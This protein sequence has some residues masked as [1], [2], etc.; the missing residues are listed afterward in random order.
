MGQN[1]LNA[2]YGLTVFNRTGSAM[3]GIV[4]AGAAPARSPREVAERSDVLITVLTD[5]AAV[6]NIILGPGGVAEGAHRGLTV[7]D[8]STIS[9]SV[10]K[11]ISQSLRSKG[12]S[13]L[14]APV[15]GGDKGAREGTLTIMVGGRTDTFESCLPIL[16]VLGKKVAHMGPSGA[17]QFAKLANQILVACNTAGVCECLAFAEK[18]GLDTTKM[19]ES[20]SAGAASSWALANLGPKMTARDFAPGFKVKLLDKD[21]GYVLSAGERLNAFLPATA[22]VRELYGRLEEKGLGDQGTQALFTVLE[23]GDARR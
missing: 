18:A 14:D 10:T 16:E 13:M 17:G 9:P 23:E 19:I 12:V 22:L 20:L 11:S 7:I 3:E 5:S 4:S 6:E 1:L 2:G 8:M 15:S 21:L